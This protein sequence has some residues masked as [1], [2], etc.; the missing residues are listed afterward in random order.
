MN[1]IVLSNIG[2]FITLLL[3]Q[4]LIFNN[5]DLFGS[6]NPF[7]YILFIILYPSSGNKALLYLT[8]FLLGLAV[9]MFINSAG[10]HAAASLILAFARPMILKFSFGISY[11]YHNLNILKKVTKDIF[12]SLEVFSYISISILVHNIT[13]FAL[14][15]F[16]FSFVLEILSRTIITM[17]TTL[18]CSVLIIYLIKPSKK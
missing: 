5:I 7:P 14:E 12:N 18:L 17:I 15:L 8:S 6:I 3:V 1:S 9:D 4:V 10:I 2:R 13:L 16:R 11:Q